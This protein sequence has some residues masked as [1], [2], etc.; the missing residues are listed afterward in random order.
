MTVD[1]KLSAI[2]IGA[3]YGGLATAIELARNGIKVKVFEAV[4]KLTNQG[5]LLSYHF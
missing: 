1:D 2:V 5:M 3:G 4:S